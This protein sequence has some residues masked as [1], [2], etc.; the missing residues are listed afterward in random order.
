MVAVGVSDGVGVSVGVLDGVAE[1]TGVGVFAALDPSETSPR[2]VRALD[3]VNVRALIG[4]NL[5]M[6]S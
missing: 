3:E 6:G 1:G 5:T 2:K 4:I